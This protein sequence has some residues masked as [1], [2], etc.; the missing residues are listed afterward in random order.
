[1]IYVFSIGIHSYIGEEALANDVVDVVGGSMMDAVVA[2]KECVITEYGV[3]MEMGNQV[4]IMHQFAPMYFSKDAITA[5]RV[6][7]DGHELSKLF[8]TTREQARKDDIARRTGIQI[9]G[10]QTGR[11]PQGGMRPAANMP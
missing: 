10:A 7:T 8:R 5:V 11:Q 6:L 4:G 3:L 1:M 2:K 9:A